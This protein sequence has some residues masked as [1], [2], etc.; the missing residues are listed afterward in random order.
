MYSGLKD[1]AMALGF[2]VENI[3]RM[4][5][6]RRRIV[7]MGHDAGGVS[8]HLHMLSPLTQD[9]FGAAISHSGN[10]FS[11]WAFSSSRNFTKR[12]AEG[13][14]CSTKTSKDMIRCM[15]GISAKKLV[16]QQYQLY[17]RKQNFIFMSFK[18]I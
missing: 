12:L 3:E 9:L 11:H 16:T 14:W 17:V 1:Q 13:F 7:L 2:I 6:D 8:A 5:G 18:R 15:R 4:G 10:G